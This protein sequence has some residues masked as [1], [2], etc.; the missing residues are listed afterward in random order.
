MNDKAVHEQL[1]S[2]EMV[3]EE[4]GRQGIL[5]QVVWDAFRLQRDKHY[6]L[7][8]SFDKSLWEWTLIEAKREKKCCP[9]K[10]LEAQN[11]VERYYK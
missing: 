1:E 6:D 4:A 8:K 7:L 2:L 5:T 10:L 11:N 3:L 9:H